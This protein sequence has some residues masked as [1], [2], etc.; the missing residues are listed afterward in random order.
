MTFVRAQRYL[1]ENAQAASAEH[2]FALCMRL[3]RIH[4]GIRK[5]CVSNN[6]DGA[7]RAA[8]LESI[9]L[10]AGYRVGRMT[11]QETEDLRSR[12]R[13][14]GQPISH[15][16]VC[17]LTEQIMQGIDGLRKESG[18][19][20]L[21]GF[22]SEQK[23]CALALLAFCCHGCDVIIFEVARDYA[24]DSMS[25]AAPYSLVMPCGFGIKDTAQ[26]KKQ[27]HDACLAIKRGTREVVTGFT[28]GEVYNLISQACAAAG[29][30]LTVPAKS[31]AVVKESSLAKMEFTYRGKG[32][33]RLHSS[34]SVQFEAALAAIE[35]CFALRRDGVRLPGVAIAAGLQK[36]EVPLCFDVLTVRPGVI[37]SVTESAED[38]CALLGAMHQKQT[39][40]GGRVVL[41]VQGTPDKL[42]AAF[43]KEF[44]TEDSYAVE[45][46]IYVGQ[47]EL[48]HESLPVT[49]C[50]TAKRAAKHIL[51]HTDPEV[52]V[53][54]TGTPA[55][56][57]NIKEA[58]GDALIG[59]S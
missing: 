10:S 27:A 24:S 46:I 2:F 28:G 1:K 18:D 39:S 30:R 17:E 20:A 43:E 58:V 42:L 59:L 54:C 9:L 4:T 48:L 37:V 56:A 14:D 34:Y 51:S 49:A 8:Y 55:F 32:P 11:G 53:L 40:F 3:G 21:G 35:A 15:K 47:G 45:E 16:L 33:Y 12:I 22:D 7:C 5:V 41:C 6:V 52:T 31:E 38:V 50:A 23:I 44:S 57:H 25:V 19:N 29:S 26:A 13:L 36:A